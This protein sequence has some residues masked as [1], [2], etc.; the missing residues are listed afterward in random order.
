MHLQTMTAREKLLLIDAPARGMRQQGRLA[1]QRCFAPILA[2]G[3]QSFHYARRGQP[4]VMAPAIRPVAPSKARARPPGGGRSHPR[5]RVGGATPRTSHGGRSLQF[6]S[7]PPRGG[8]PRVYNA[9]RLGTQS[10]GFRESSIRLSKINRA[11]ACRLRVCCR[12]QGQQTSARTS[13]H[14]CVS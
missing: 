11:G 14:P 4:R 12:P 5:P 3:T 7:T 9:L 13:Q 6:Q 2:T 10:G 8:R 1:C